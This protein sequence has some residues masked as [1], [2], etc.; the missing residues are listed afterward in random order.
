MS[1]SNVSTPV[2]VGVMGAG[3]V[4]RERHIPAF[5]RD[6]RCNV[7]ML[8]DQDYS[9]AESV[10]R[11]FRVPRFVNR[12]EDFLQE[13]LDVVSICTPPWTH[14]PL[15]EAAIRAGKH[16]LVEKPMTLTSEEGKALD[17]LAHKSGLVL[18][19]VHNFLFSH[20]MQRAKSLLEG[21]A[22]GVVN[23]TMGVQL[24]SWSRRL[25]TWFKELPGGLFFDEAPHFLY[26]MRYFLG[27]LRV[28]Q[29]WRYT[30]ETDSGLLNERM[31]ARLCGTR[32]IGQLTMWTGS[33]FSEWL[34]ILFCSRAVLVL[35]LFR[36]ILI[37][38]PPERAHN[39]VDVLKFSARSTFQLWREIGASGLR[40]AG[41]RLLYGHDRLVNKFLEAVI[42]REEPPVT[43]QDGFEVVALIEEILNHTSGARSE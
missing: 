2:R 9:Q 21:G 30:D 18:C 34:F 42:E 39:A 41:N 12:L 7:T 17:I 10:A 14:A 36:D 43:A 1:H 20:S 19:P 11:K 4:A 37:H 13:P 35:D 16:V 40:F 31:E 24:N 38:L 23:W 5:K 28:E 29:A 25:P 15:I 6:G 33:P 27:E 26:L 32:G 22:A 8:F 3:W